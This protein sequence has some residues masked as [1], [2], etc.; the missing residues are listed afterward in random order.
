MTVSYF[1][2]FDVFCYDNTQFCMTCLHGKTLGVGIIV[3]PT[4]DRSTD[5]QHCMISPHTE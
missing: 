3:A 4:A 1:E 2:Q 5:Q